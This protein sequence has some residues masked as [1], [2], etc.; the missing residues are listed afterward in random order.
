MAFQ[1]VDL[2]LDHRRRAGHVHHVPVARERPQRPFLAAAA[3]HDGRMGTLDAAR[4]EGRGVEMVVLAV[5]TDRS[6]RVE[7]QLDQLH[8]FLES[9]LP[10]AHRRERDA[11]HAVFRLMP[12]RTDAELKPPVADVIDGRRHL[13]QHRWLAVRHARD[14]TA[15]PD[16]VGDGRERGERRPAL[17]A[18]AAEILAN[19]RRH[20]V[21]ERPRAVELRLRVEEP[22][23]V[24]ELA[25]RDAVDAGLDPEAHLCHGSPSVQADRPSRPACSVGRCDC[26][27]VLRSAD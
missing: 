19:A 1:D 20:E 24:G 4:S 17:E 9:I 10:F 6:V 12:R 15:E 16:A 5:E 3:H 25:P 27:L 13:G 23:H 26:R 2:A 11:V 21:V 8:G 22:P 7:E 18:T 14:E